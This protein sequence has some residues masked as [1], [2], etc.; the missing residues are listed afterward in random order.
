M[1]PCAHFSNTINLSSQLERDHVTYGCNEYFFRVTLKKKKKK[2]EEKNVRNNHYCFKY[3]VCNTIIPHLKTIKYVS[4]MKVT[5]IFAAV[6]MVLSFG[7]M[8]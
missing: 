7:K 3:F 8:K 2:I 1:K 6:K 4:I 5:G